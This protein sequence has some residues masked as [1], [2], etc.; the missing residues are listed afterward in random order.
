MA[1]FRRM[2]YD[3]VT[4]GAVHIRMA[5]GD[6]RIPPVSEDF[7]RQPELAGRSEADT[8]LLE[9]RQEDPAAEALFGSMKPSVDLESD[10][11]RLVWSEWPPPDYD[12]AAD[13]RAA[14]EYLGVGGTEEASE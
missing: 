4:G 13:M 7:G 5:K 10:P 11:P 1:F 3:R 14:L 9:W 8:A 12:E 6:L 2:Y